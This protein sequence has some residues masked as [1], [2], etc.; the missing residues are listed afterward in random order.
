MA[1]LNVGKLRHHGTHLAH[2]KFST[3]LREG[4]KRRKTDLGALE[5]VD[6]A[7]LADI[8]EAHDADCH[9][10]RCARLVSL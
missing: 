4:E 6:Q 5:R 8:R 7:A 10:L 2:A 9:A 1:M 3:T